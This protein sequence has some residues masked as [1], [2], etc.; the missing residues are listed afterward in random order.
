MP[1]EIRK[2]SIPIH[3]HGMDKDLGCR[4]HIITG[5]VFGIGKLYPVKCLLKGGHPNGH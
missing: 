4:R 5:P 3:Y 2:E 1:V